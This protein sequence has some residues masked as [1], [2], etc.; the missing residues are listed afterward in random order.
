MKETIWFDMDGTIANLYGVENW[1]EKLINNNPSPYLE[2]KPL[3]NMNTLAKM[4]H[5]VQNKGY[6][7]GIISWLSK[8]STP[9][10]DKQVTTAKHKWLKGKPVH[11]YR[12][13]SG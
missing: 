2:A 10:Y 11:P 3:L 9:E 8:N 5:K 6:Q 1:L 7:I 12:Q 4:L 13:S